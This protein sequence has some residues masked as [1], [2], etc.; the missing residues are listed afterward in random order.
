MGVRRLFGNDLFAGSIAEHPAGLRLP[1]PKVA[2]FRCQVV[3]LP[4]GRQGKPKMRVK[5]PTVDKAASA[6]TMLLLN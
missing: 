4:D 5:S 6:A 1:M 3:N 2:M